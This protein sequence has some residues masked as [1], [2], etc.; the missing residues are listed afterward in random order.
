VKLVED[1]TWTEPNEGLTETEIA[2][3]LTTEI[4][5]EADF[6]VSAIDVA[7]RV[8]AAGFGKATGAV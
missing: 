1:D 3:A 7:R 8:T 2:G 5:E 6:V 4:A